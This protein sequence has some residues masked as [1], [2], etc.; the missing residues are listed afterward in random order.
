MI[1]S[2]SKIQRE[3]TW[4]LRYEQSREFGY[5]ISFCKPEK[6]VAAMV[7]LYAKLAKANFIQAKSLGRR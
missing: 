4:T 5:T 6:N 3:Q 7:K 1:G 2:L